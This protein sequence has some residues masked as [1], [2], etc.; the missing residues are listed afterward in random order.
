MAARRAGLLIHSPFQRLRPFAEEA[1]I[2]HVAVH[3]VALAPG[4]LFHEINRDEALECGARNV[5]PPPRFEVKAPAG[6]ANGTIIAQGGRFGGWSLSVKNGVPA[7]DY[8]F[9]G[10]IPKVTVEVK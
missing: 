3:A 4:R 1:D 2:R 10:R 8:N 7:C 6:G 5:T 9:P